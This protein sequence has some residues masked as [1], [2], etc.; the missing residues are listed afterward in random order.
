M[1]RNDNEVSGTAMGAAAGTGFLTILNFLIGLLVC[2]LSCIL[3]FNFN[4]IKLI[5]NNG[6][7]TIR[8]CV[9]EIPMDVSLIH[10]WLA[11]MVYNLLQYI[12]GYMRI[13]NYISVFLNTILFLDYKAVLVFVNIVG[14]YLIL[15]RVKVEYSLKLTMNA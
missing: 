10:I 12:I 2:I 1:R 14:W 8:T 5:D 6:I 11:F 3:Y 9:S 13:S 15:R 4:G 7:I